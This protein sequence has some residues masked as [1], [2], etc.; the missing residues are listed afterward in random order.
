MNNRITLRNSQKKKKLLC[1]WGFDFWKFQQYSTWHLHMLLT[2]DASNDSPN[3]KD[4]KRAESSLAPTLL[5]EIV[6]TRVSVEHETK[7]LI[8]LHLI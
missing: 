7:W 3:Q 4:G 1:M 2:T 5:I 6:F 8:W